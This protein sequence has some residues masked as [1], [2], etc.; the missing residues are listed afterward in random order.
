M[1]AVKFMKRRA[2]AKPVREAFAKILAVVPIASQGAV[3]S[4]ITLPNQKA[5]V[6][7]GLKSLEKKT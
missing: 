1:I 2:C 5:F 3:A 4:E 7:F 6:T